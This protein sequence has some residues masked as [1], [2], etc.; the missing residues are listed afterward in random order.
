[1]FRHLG[2]NPLTYFFGRLGKLTIILHYYFLTGVLNP[3]A[4]FLIG[5]LE[6]LIVGASRVN[7]PVNLVTGQLGPGP[8]QH[9]E[10]PNASTYFNQAF[11]YY[12]ML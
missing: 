12:K 10:I 5:V 8:G 3:C 11:S 2:F 1:M 9:P 6:N 4:L 7:W